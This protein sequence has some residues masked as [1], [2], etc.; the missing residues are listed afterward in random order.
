MTCAQNLKDSF[1]LRE[2]QP[3][4]LPTNYVWFLESAALFTLND[5]LLT[6]VPS[7]AGQ[8][9]G[10]SLRHSPAGERNHILYLCYAALWYYCGVIELQN[11]DGKQSYLNDKVQK[12]LLHVTVYKVTHFPSSQEFEEVCKFRPPHKTLWSHCFPL[13]HDHLYHPLGTTRI[14]HYT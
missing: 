8:S 14:P 12:T 5:F 6:L 3:T 7:P 4:F 13:H 9:N 10:R 1:L 2:H 11:T